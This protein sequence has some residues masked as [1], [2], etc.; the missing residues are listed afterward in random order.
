MIGAGGV[1]TRSTVVEGLLAAN[2]AELVA[3]CDVD[4]ELERTVR[5]RREEVRRVATIGELLRAGIDAVFVASDVVSRA[6]HILSA[7]AAGKHILCEEAP[8]ADVG[9]TCRVIEICRERGVLL[10][11]AFFLRF[12]PESQRV[13]GLIRDRV[14]GK[15]MYGRMLFSGRGNLSGNAAEHRTSPLTHVGGHC[16]DL[17]EMF[18]GEARMLHCFAGE[19][20]GKSGPE[21]STVVSLYFENGVMA[22]IY[23]SLSG[24]NSMSGNVFELYGSQGRVAVEVNGEGKVRTSLRLNDRPAE[25]VIREPRYRVLP[26]GMSPYRAEIE[27]FCCAI[28]EGDTPYNSAELGLRNQY[29]IEACLRS[30]REG[31][32]VNLSWSETI[33]AC[34]GLICCV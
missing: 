28:L 26:D 25:E 19:T 17:L 18:F 31:I 15:L 2:H 7:A 29:L 13:L 16:I 5:M 1:F 4:R 9:Q 3:L 27:E 10:G 22:H 12:L 21:G 32:T 23:V 33:L 34:L 11:S 14:L 6:D 8:G 20:E 30:M 24:E